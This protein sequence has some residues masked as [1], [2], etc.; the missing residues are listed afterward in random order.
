MKQ[1]YEIL[2]DTR[3]KKPLPFPEHVSVWDRDR[4]HSQRTVGIRTR[5]HKMAVG[6]YAIE[7]GGVL[8]ERKGSL[9]EV[10]Q[11]CMSRD[12]ARFLD[13]LDRMHAAPERAVLVLEETPSSIVKQESR[14]QKVQ[15]A[16]DA[17]M[18]ELIV[19]D[20]SLILVQTNTL[21][22]RRD[23]ARLVARLLIAGAL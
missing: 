17:L 20:I 15:G 6:D 2:V 7:G 5:S 1:T 21:A 18:D 14:N 11:N 13:C 16:I 19:R 8:V 23:A 22:Q 12:R 10:A 4:W 3:E 9:R